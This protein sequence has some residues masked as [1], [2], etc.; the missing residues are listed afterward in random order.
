MTALWQRA[1]INENVG[2]SLNT[3]THTST[4]SYWLLIC[5]GITVFYSPWYYTHKT[6]LTPLLFLLMEL[7]YS[8]ASHM[9]SVY[10]KDF[11]S[12]GTSMSKTGNIYTSKDTPW[13]HTILRT[14][15]WI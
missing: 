5:Q 12:P 2:T 15:A 4:I 8:N 7:A 1:Q 11:H 10:S 14:A 3:A 9:P 13:E 6:W